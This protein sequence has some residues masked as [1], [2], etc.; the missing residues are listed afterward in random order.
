MAGPDGVK[1]PNLHT[2]KEIVNP[3]RIVWFARRQANAGAAFGISGE[4]G[5]D[6]RE[7][8]KE[9]AMKITNALVLA[10]GEKKQVLIMGQ[11]GCDRIG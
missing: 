1:Y 2:F 4:S 3:E 10:A 11:S 7:T 8:F 5:N 6:V 9:K